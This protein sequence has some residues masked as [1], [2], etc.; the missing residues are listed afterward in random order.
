MKTLKSL[1]L[2]SSV[3]LFAATGA[4]AADLIAEPAADYVKVCDAFGTGFYYI[5]GTETCL[6]ISGEIRFFMVFDNNGRYTGDRVPGVQTVNVN[7]NQS[8]DFEYNMESLFRVRFD[9]RSQTELGTLRGFA[10]YQMTSGGG[11]NGG[12]ATGARFAFVQLGGFLAGQSTSISNLFATPLMWGGVASGGDNGNRRIN[13]LSYT[14]AAGNGISASIALEDAGS[15]NGSATGVNEFDNAAPSVVAT[16]RVAQS[17]GSF[18]VTG[19][20]VDND[21]VTA[22]LPNLD[23]GYMIGA[24]ALVNVGSAG[25]FNAGIRYSEDANF[26][27]TGGYNALVGANSEVFLAYAGYNH[28]FSSKLSGVI[29]VEYVDTDNKAAGGF[30]YNAFEIVGGLTYTPVAGMNIGLEVYYVDDEINNV[31]ARDGN[32][33][34]LLRIRRTF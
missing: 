8:D 9:A 25:R 11:A 7:G 23:T 34:G 32:F 26:Y 31:D 4:Q 28:N 20:I 24:G 16:V 15:D 2:G 18:A 29:G 33:H 3:A 30:D 6:R 19:A 5:P 14:Y 27:T 12:G 1:L 13:Q 21:A 22:A 10:E 17:W